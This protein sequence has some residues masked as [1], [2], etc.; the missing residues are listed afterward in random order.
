MAFKA[1]DFAVAAAG[2]ALALQLNE[3]G[4][5]HLIHSNHAAAL[6]ALGDHTGALAAAEASLVGQPGFV[7]GH[8]RKALALTSLSRWTAAI[9]ACEE[10]CAAGLTHVI[11][12]CM[13]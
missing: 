10:G 4:E 9:E 6:S 1:G 5:P 3:G 2:F 7:K 11:C 13:C 12:M 8:Y